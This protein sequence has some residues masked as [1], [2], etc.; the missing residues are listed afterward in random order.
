MPFF[1]FIHISWNLPYPDSDYVNGAAIELDKARDC[2]PTYVNK[3]AIAA[4]A[5]SDGPP[6]YPAPPRP[7]VTHAAP[8]TTTPG[9][10]Y[11]NSAVLNTGTQPSE[12]DYGNHQAVR[13]AAAHTGGQSSDLYD[14]AA[15]T[16]DNSSDQQDNPPSYDEAQSGVGTR[17]IGLVAEMQRR[18]QLRNP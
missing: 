3:V 2:D 13:Q 16:G 18:L 5:G 17:N 8:H 11:G 14:T 15:V 10:V 7:T 1:T 12:G 9:D 6:N 4:K